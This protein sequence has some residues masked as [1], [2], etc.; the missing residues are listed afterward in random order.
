M[1]P[2]EIHRICETLFARLR[3][4]PDWAGFENLDTIAAKGRR[5]LILSVGK[6]S[7][8]LAKALIAKVNQAPHAKEHW[9]HGDWKAVVTVPAHVVA[10]FDVRAKVYFVDHP[11]STPRNHAASVAVKNAIESLTPDDC[12]LV[13]LSGGASAHL[14]LPAPGVDLHEMDLLFSHLRA[15]GANISELNTVR[16]HCGV[17]KG[18][19][20]AMLTRAHIE[21]CVLSDVIGDRL[22]V[23]GSGP[24]VADPTSLSDAVAVLTKYNAQSIAPSVNKVLADP[25]S[26]SP[27]PGDTHLARINHRLIG[28]NQRAID[29]FAKILE[30]SSIKVHEK[31]ALLQGD[32]ASLGRQL[33]R[34]ASGFV[35]AGKHGA[36]IF[37]GEPTVDARNAPKICKG[38]PSQELALAGVIE[39][40]RLGVDN[41][42]IL[43]VSTDGIDG[44]SE[45]A[46]ACGTRNACVHA[47]EQGTPAAE[48]LANHDS[49]AFWSHFNGAI[50][51]GL[52]GTNLNHVAAAIF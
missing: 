44:E 31:R 30:A 18:G 33:A 29:E 50:R 36:V 35:A 39:L 6:A 47:L 17:L 45:F 51:T 27:K 9:Q 28:N 4:S 26:E 19:R 14:A 40:D 34:V 21:V 10:D 15:S 43:A 23:I 7:V 11:H 52:S 37:G 8:S 25:A 5:L 48:F 12:L 38:G 16:K 3:P 2:Q 1:K 22:D 41:V 42:S 13:G 49:S 46:G 24:F 32:A 20:A